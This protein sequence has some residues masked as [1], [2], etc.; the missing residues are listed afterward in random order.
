M[1]LNL[2]YVVFDKDSIVYDITK[3]NNERLYMSVSAGEKWT[4]EELFERF[5]DSTRLDIVSMDMHSKNCTFQQKNTIINRT[6]EFLED[7][8]L[9]P[10]ERMV[11][12]DI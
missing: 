12:F 3:T 9:I 1:L 5:R 7:D 10:N 8:K 6:I 2:E 4:R 11:I